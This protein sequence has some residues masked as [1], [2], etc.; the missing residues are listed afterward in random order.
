MLDYL[1][2]VYP[3]TK[4]NF[5]LGTSWVWD[6]QPFTRGA[7]CVYQPGELSTLLPAAIMPEKRM[8]FAGEHCSSHPAWMQGALESGIR[9]AEMVRKVSFV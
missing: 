9:A 4:D 5:E 3:G 1:D 7:Y 2:K 6:E 8:L